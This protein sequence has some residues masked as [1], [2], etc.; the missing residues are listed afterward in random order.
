MATENANPADAS[1]FPEYKAVGIMV[2]KDVTRH[3]ADKVKVSSATFTC[4]EDP[5][6][7]SFRITL[8]GTEA[9]NLIKVL[10]SNTS[11]AVTFLRPS[12]AFTFLDEEM[13]PLCRQKIA[14][15]TTY[16]AG[17][18]FLAGFD[19]LRVFNNKDLIIVC[20]VNYVHEVPEIVST[21]DTA[22]P[23]NLL[24]LS[25]QMSYLLDKSFDSDFTLCVKSSRINENVR[26][27]RKSAKST[28]STEIC[29]ENLECHKDVLMARSSYFRRLLQS[30]MKESQSNTVTMEDASPA[31]Y[32]LLLK[33]LYTGQL[34]VDSAENAFDLL[35]LAEKYALDDLKAACEIAIRSLVT[36]DN[37]I[38]TIVLADRHHSREL[39][40]HCLPLFKKNMDDLKSKDEW[41][42]LKNL[43]DLFERLLLACNKEEALPLG[44]SGNDKDSTAC[45]ELG[46]LM[47]LSGD[48]ARMVD[49]DKTVPDQSS[50]TDITLILE[51]GGRVGA[52]RCIL[53]ALDPPLSLNMQNRSRKRFELAGNPAAVRECI[54]FWYSCSP[55]E[56]LESIAFELLPVAKKYGGPE[57]FRM[58]DMALR[59]ILS[60]ENVVDILILNEVHNVPGLFHYCLPVYKANALLL[61]EDCKKKLRNHPNLLLKLA[62]GCSI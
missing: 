21:E 47:Q 7:T 22:L 20:D 14:C 37:V 12:I 59:R 43:P 16:K 41:Q 11:R 27:L 28:K 30:G 33:F 4:D 53:L 44:D 49:V 5:L 57:L 61:K 48:L 32:R 15:S 60:V 23:E 10:V 13:M 18:S 17:S 38:S 39:F 51:D 35:P 6:R 24:L 8:L 26:N 58:C 2:V 40:R 50:C 9:G 31:L 46:F 42:T 62:A 45:V 36:V 1:S 29:Y 55:P 56:N 19:F 25:R 52:H 3:F 34:P 54:K